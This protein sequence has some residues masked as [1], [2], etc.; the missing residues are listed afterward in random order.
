MRTCEAVWQQGKG[1]SKVTLQSFETISCSKSQRK[2]SDKDSAPVAD[3]KQVFL[4]PS[5]Q[6]NR[7][8]AL[9]HF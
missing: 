2:L 7:G 9:T 6:D 5:T 8:R 4:P 3:Q 1:V